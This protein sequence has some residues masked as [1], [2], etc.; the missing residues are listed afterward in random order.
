MMLFQYLRICNIQWRDNKWIMNCKGFGKKR[1]WPNLRYYPGICLEGLR[2]PWKTSVMITGLQPEILI[3]TSWIQSSSVN[4]ST[5]ALV[6][7][8]QA[9]L[10]LFW[11]FGIHLTTPVCYCCWQLWIL[12]LVI[13]LCLSKNV[14][15]IIS[16]GD[17]IIKYE[18]A[19]LC[20]SVVR[21]E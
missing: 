4:P 6:T 5:M 15:F 11:S 8:H 2:K 12:I 16:R 3:G 18:L 9:Q 10:L 17:F 19:K 14:I 21:K 13:A 20:C 7:K 1:T